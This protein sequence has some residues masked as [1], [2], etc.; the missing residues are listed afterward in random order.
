V[1][2]W[3]YHALSTGAARLFRL[4]GLQPG[5]DITIG[6]AASLAGIAPGQARE[7]LAEL[8]R[9]HLLAEHRPGRY[10]SHDLLRAYAAEQEHAHHDAARHTAV[11][12]VLGH[13]LH[14]VQR[15]E[16]GI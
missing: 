15:S 9:G 3:S 4:L 11:G 6:A 8:T 16:C 7:L 13:R 2:S 14:A 1:F 5:P 12:R 10:A